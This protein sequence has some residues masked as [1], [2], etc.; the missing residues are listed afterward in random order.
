MYLE[1]YKCKFHLA[2]ALNGSNIESM[3]FSIIDQINILQQ[4]KRKKIL[5]EDETDFMPPLTTENLKSE[6]MTTNT[7][8]N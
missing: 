8:E 5:Q 2:S 6:R 1:K 3:F 7:G 4:T